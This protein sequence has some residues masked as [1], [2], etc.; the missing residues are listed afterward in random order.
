LAQPTAGKA[1]VKWHIGGP[2]TISS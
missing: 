2:S 1:I